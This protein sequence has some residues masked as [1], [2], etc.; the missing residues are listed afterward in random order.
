MKKIYLLFATLG[1]IACP[2]F[3]NAEEVYYTNDNG[4]E[5]TEEQ[6][7]HLEEA[8]DP[9][10]IRVMTKE[11]FTIEMENNYQNPIKELKYFRT[12]YKKDINGNI[13]D[14]ITSEVSKGD[15][16]NEVTPVPTVSRAAC[17]SCKTYET[18]YKIL[19]LIV[20]PGN[21]MNAPVRVQVINT[22]KKIP[23]VKQYD[24]IG[25]RLSTS[26][27]S[28]PSAGV[29]EY[30]AHQIWDGNVWSYS[31]L[32]SNM[33]MKSNGVA[34]VMNIADDVKTSLKNEMSTYM[35][36]DPADL[37]V[38]ASYQHCTWNDITK[39]EAM[40][41]TFSGTAS[42]GYKILGGVYKYKDSVAKKYDQTAGVSVL[43]D[44]MSSI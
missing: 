20:T 39:S 34:E 25:F 13:V 6:Y 43:F 18:E 29:N 32:D 10:I 14:T 28:N 21:S 19:E 26:F 44:W 15:Y 12:D 30:Y 22:W 37:T 31:L 2:M 9:A 1:M 27:P 16:E 23:S 24:I 17:K 8:F 40:S 35:K 11:Q 42:S 38:Y 4:I 7:K 3:A 36:T 33:I 5:M 41:V